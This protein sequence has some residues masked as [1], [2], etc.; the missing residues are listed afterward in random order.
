MLSRQ[1]N[2]VQLL[3]TTLPP[4]QKTVPACSSSMPKKLKEKLIES[5]TLAVASSGGAIFARLCMTCNRTFTGDTTH[6]P[7]DKSTLVAVDHGSLIGTMVGTYKILSL[8]GEGG[9][10]VVYKAEH[11]VMQRIVALKMMRSGVVG[12]EVIMRFQQEA[13]AVS[14][15]EH[16][17]I[18]TIYGCE[19]SEEGNPFLVMEH[20]DGKTLEDEEVRANLSLEEAVDVF[21]QLCDALGHAHQKGVIH[22]DLKPANIIFSHCAD[23]ILPMNVK[24][25]DFGIAKLLPS[26]G[27]EM[28]DLTRTGQPVGSPS[29]MSPEQCRAEELDARSDI[30]SLGCV[31]YKLISGK[32]PFEGTSLFAVMAKHLGEQPAPFSKVNPALRVPIE[33]EE[34]ILKT[35]E[36]RRERRYESM[37]ELKAALESL[38]IRRR[39]LVQ[40]WFL[41]FKRRLNRKA[42][43]A[44]AASAIVLTGL[45]C[46]QNFYIK[47]VPVKE[48]WQHHMEDGQKYLAEHKYKEADRSLKEAL[49]DANKIGKLSRYV[50][51]TLGAL[52]QSK[53]QQGQRDQANRIEYEREQVVWQNYAVDLGD[54][55]Q[56]DKDIKQL[57]E[58]S[59][60]HP[61]DPQVNLAL[62]TKCNNQ[63]RILLL[64]KSLD[65]SESMLKMAMELES[66][67]FPTTL[68]R[69]RAITISCQNLAFIYMSDH[70]KQL[71]KAQPLLERAHQLSGKIFGMAQLAGIP[72]TLYLAELWRLQRRSNKALSLVKE[73]EGILS[74]IEGK[75]SDWMARCLRT[76]ALVHEDQAQF[77]TAKNSYIAA[78]HIQQKLFGENVSDCIP[79]YEGLTRIAK[80]QKDE[81]RAAYWQEKANN[82]YKQ[83]NKI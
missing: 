22:R 62:V 73:A 11:V 59:E 14:A 66:G 1:I 68:E 82:C 81:R 38:R 12:R 64:N 23:G 79:L 72:A 7:D 36:K 35:L 77:E 71:E 61:Q 42:V 74:N 5:P 40:S 2:W 30:Y 24:I 20:V 31:M 78:L 13:K 45:W 32:P 83:N 19:V 60:T 39:S 6:C 37:A 46:F 44:A 51:E 47:P 50:Y 8:I 4:R 49:T 55:A 17:N 3:L 33:L 16:P 57:V 67:P 65:R 80:I 75:G 28:F 21:I 48:A 15:L 58:Q 29:Y 56:N 27:K 25:L 53:E 54:I 10:G 69:D 26:S 52:R 18:V 76:E 9:M 34:I 43:A 41:Y 63:G 70:E